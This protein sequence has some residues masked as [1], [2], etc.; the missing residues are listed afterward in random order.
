MVVPYLAAAKVWQGELLAIA[1]LETH[2]MDPDS[3]IRIPLD[4]LAP[5]A[6][7]GVIEEFVTRDGT[8]LVDADIKVRQVRAQLERGEV[9]IRFDENTR[10]C[11]IVVT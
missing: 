4:Q 11:N 3:G 8:D 6:L 7:L 2:N 9:E 1:G 5:D 10:S